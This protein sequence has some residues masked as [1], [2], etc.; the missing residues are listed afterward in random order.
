LAL[1]TVS[2]VS[3][4]AGMDAAAK[5]TAMIAMA[6]RAPRRSD[7]VIRPPPFNRRVLAAALGTKSLYDRHRANSELASAVSAM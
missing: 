5:N 4:E 1:P 7:T 2:V 3:A 6:A